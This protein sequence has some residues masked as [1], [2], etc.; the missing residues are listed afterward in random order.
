MSLQ[1]FAKTPEWDELKQMLLDEFELKPLSINTD[2]LSP[3]QIAVEVRASQIANDRMK[4]FMRKIQT[5][6]TTMEKES[7]K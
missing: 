6:L 7:W 4:K 5:K 3:E 2:K 1:N